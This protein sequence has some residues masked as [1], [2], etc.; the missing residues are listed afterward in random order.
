MDAEQ[1]GEAWAR[2]EARLPAGWLL[3]SLRCASE[4]L[5]PAD[6]SDDW[7]AVAIGPDG[8]E[9][10]HRAPDALAALAGLA[11]DFEPA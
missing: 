3:D 2:T 5:A 8:A 10:V 9:R 11:R 7:V 1:I 6:R 4:S